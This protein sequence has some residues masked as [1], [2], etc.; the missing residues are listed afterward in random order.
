MIRICRLLLL[1]LFLFNTFS[2]LSQSSDFLL[3]KKK[4]KT[5]HSYYPG[6]NIEF[7]TVNNIYRNGVISSLHNDSI[8]ISEYLV[9][10]LPTTLG[11]VIYDTAG[12]FRFAYPYR[13]IAV[14]GPKSKKGFDFKSSGYSLFGGGILLLLGSGVVYQV[15]RDKFS[16]ALARTCRWTESQMHGWFRPTERR[17]RV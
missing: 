1:S 11:T 17:P 10:Q 3:L 4:D 5:L 12:S 13:D 8:F 6:S 2:A 16:P 14:V 15:D 7:T 9:R